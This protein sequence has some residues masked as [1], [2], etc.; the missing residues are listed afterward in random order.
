MSR[1]VTELLLLD[2]VEGRIT[3]AAWSQVPGGTRVASWSE[4]KDRLGLPLGVPLFV[5]APGHVP[6]RPNPRSKTGGPRPPSG[7]RSPGQT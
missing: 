1:G 7:L 5:S 3:S 4:D 6:D 2:D